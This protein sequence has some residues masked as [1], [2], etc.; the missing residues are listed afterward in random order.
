[1]RRA[2]GGGRRAA[3]GGRAGGDRRA[4]G[5]T[6]PDGPCGAVRMGLCEEPSSGQVYEKRSSGLSA[7]C[8]HAKGG[9]RAE[10][11]VMGSVISCRVAVLLR[12]DGSVKFWGGC[13]HNSKESCR[14]TAVYKVFG[15]MGRGIVGSVCMGTAGVIFCG[16]V[17]KILGN[18]KMG[19][20]LCLKARC[21][22][23]LLYRF[24]C[25]I[26]HLALTE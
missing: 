6:G 18:I 1:M 3:G 8:V 5:T 20:I 24:Y 23:E 10:S 15:F 12:R 16:T 9:L 21:R 2:A 14:N 17:I 22:V 13:A 7:L 19:L 11:R 26:E 25:E 4:A